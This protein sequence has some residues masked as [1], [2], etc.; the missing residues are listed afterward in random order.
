MW[1]V[2]VLW[3]YVEGVI[4]VKVAASSNLALVMASLNG[5]SSTNFLMLA[6]T[7]YRIALWGEPGD[8]FESCG[9]AAA[10]VKKRGLAAYLKKS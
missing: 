5:S 10:G 3:C 7:I 1:Q 2:A 4:T 8:L 9:S 6:L